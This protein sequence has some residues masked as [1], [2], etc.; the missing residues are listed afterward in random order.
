MGEE[1]AV[2]TSGN[3]GYVSGLPVL[4]GRLNQNQDSQG[5]DRYIIWAIST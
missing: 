1:D 5:T 2:S 4:A 3:P